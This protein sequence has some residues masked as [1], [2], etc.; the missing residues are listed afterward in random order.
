MVVAELKDYEGRVAAHSR[1]FS[2]LF[3]P[4]Y[5]VTD[6]GP[7][8]RAWQASLS[9]LTEVRRVVFPLD[10]KEFCIDTDQVSHSARVWGRRYGRGLGIVVYC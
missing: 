3:L 2:K 4:D 1:A 8:I 6:Q 5:A 10:R 7:R 9:N